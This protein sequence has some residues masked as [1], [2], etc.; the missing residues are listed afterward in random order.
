MKVSIIT[1]G[2]NKTGYGHITR[3]LSLYQAFE[4]RNIIPT[5]YV[6][7][8]EGSASFLSEVNYEII[9]WLENQ[10]TLFR[11]IHNSDVVIV[12]SYLA[13]KEFY[14]RISLVTPSPL[15]IDDFVRL[16]YPAGTI[17][18][19]SINAETL[20]YLPRA[21]R[22]LL[23]GTKYAAIRKEFWE[24]GE[25]PFRLDIQ[26]ILV[27]F[28][29]Q[30]TENFTPRAL[31]LLTR[32]FPNVRKRVIVG[33]GFTNEEQIEQAKDENTE[34]YKAPTPQELVKLMYDS[35]LA[36]TTGGQTLVELA[37]VGV[38]A[39]A[40]SVSENQTLHMNGWFKEK[41]LLA[42]L[43]H[44]QP[45]LENRILLL[46]G[47]LRKKAPREI[48]SKIGR[49]K[50]D[51]G[52]AKRV[53]HFLIDKY[54]G[55]SGFYFRNVISKDSALLFN[56]LN[57]KLIRAN[58]VYE[59]PLKWGDHLDWFTGKLMDDDCYFLLAFTTADQFIGQVRFD[60]KGYYAEINVSIHSDWRGKGIAK[61]VVFNASFK[62]FHEKPNV[63]YIHTHIKPH[64]SQSLGVFTQAGYALTEKETINNQ[65]AIVC[66]LS[67]PR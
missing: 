17:L 59:M 12:D 64:D 36:I 47:N 52:G 24:V 46:I 37:R 55:K 16:D 6:N 18:N 34:I 13:P 20:G 11:K 62:C 54:S 28:G 39:I 14:S 67:R 48:I 2:Y 57:D 29:G 51:G 4:I 38:P 49:Q 50:V 31:R 7:G 40:I 5:F 41:F 63:G 30:D 60:I 27:T 58:S 66:K 42:E 1:E 44:N 15:F 19:G 25:R 3:C 26:N 65:D 33:S 22:T 23:L 35:D 45:N 9:D 61:L 53:V 56:L 8:D 32:N 10:D 21:D 43:L